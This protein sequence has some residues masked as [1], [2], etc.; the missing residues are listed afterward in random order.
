L[1]F[2][3][4]FGQKAY[5]QCPFVRDEKSEELGMWVRQTS[6]PIPLSYDPA[7]IWFNMHRV[8]N[9]YYVEIV[10][11]QY[12]MRTYGLILYN[13][14]VNQK[15][16]IHLINNEVLFL[17]PAQPIDETRVVER[18]WTLGE[19][20]GNLA[21]IAL[22]SSSDIPTNSILTFHPLFSI[23]FTQ[24]DHALEIGV[25]KV[26]VQCNGGEIANSTK[27]QNIEFQVNKRTNKM[28]SHRLECLSK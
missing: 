1:L 14:S 22:N 9:S 5:S 12:P 2:L 3:F 16:E 20:A 19:L 23:E 18:D 10:H 25:K 17:E 7:N 21:G 26:I 28:L 8:G 24:I 27:K 15:L 13:R 11:R 4:S 6:C